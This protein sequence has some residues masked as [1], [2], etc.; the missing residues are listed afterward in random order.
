MSAQVVSPRQQV[1]LFLSI[2]R[3]GTGGIAGLSPTVEL[4]RSSD[5]FY[6]D[7]DDDTFKASG[8]TTR[9]Q[10]L[11]DLTGGA[12]QYQIDLSAIGAV[13]KDV[14][15]A[16]YEVSGNEAAVTNDV[17]NVEDLELMR[18]VIENRLEEV[19][20]SPDGTI[21]LYDDNGTDIRKQWTSNDF[22]G[23]GTSGAPGSPA[24]RG[25]ATSP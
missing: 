20:G 24:R 15:I 3:A 8:W 4:R 19:P 17:F 2:S 18:Q 23:D 13:N 5:G 10:V 14:L 21:T 12:Y 16:F 6:L 25:K 1:P 22:N 9:K 7:F 11:T